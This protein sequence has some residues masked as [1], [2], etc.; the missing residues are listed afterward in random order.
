MEISGLII[1]DD[2]VDYLDCLAV[3]DHW[4]S[5]SQLLEIIGQNYWR[6]MN[7]FFDYWR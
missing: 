1:G 2:G 3:A 6:L 4:K 5:L 7:M